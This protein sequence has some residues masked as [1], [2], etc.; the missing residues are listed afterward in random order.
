MTVA[1]LLV[2]LLPLSCQSAT[3][4]MPV[5]T[6]SPSLRPPTPVVARVFIPGVRPRARL[7]AIGEEAPPPG[8][9]APL[10]D[11]TPEGWTDDERAGEGL[12]GFASFLRVS[13]LATAPSCLRA[14]SLVPPGGLTCVPSAYLV[15]RC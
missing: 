1:R 11:S 4:S 8:G 9:P 3:V 5:P 15:L 14:A 10:L 13:D 7:E 6:T 12:A 2:A